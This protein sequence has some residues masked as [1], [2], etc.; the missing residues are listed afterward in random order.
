[1]RRAIVL[2]GLMLGGS[3]L[4]QESPNYKLWEHVFNAGGHPPDGIVLT[5]SNYQI[6]SG[7]AGD[8]VV[9]TN[10]SSVS[11]QME[12]GFSASYPPP[13]EV[14]SLRFTDEETLAWNPDR[15]IGTYQLY[16]GSVSDLPTLGYGT[17]EQPGLTAPIASEADPLPVGEGYF[18]LV[19]AR[20]RLSEEGTKGSD[21]ADSERA[22]ADPC[23]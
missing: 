20:N 14:A 21:S 3:V 17:C 19:T 22:N 5:S 10:L 23:P 13:G 6:T 18:Y 12:G 2:L 8:T 11:F 16:R 4:A 7:S 9:G 1:M 15:S